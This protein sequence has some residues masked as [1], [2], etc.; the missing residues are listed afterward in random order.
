MWRSLLTTLALIVAL[1]FNVLAETQP[2][3]QGTIFTSASVRLTV[4]EGFYNPA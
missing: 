1:S 4:F 2:G 3:A